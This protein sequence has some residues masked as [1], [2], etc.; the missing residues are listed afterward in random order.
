MASTDRVLPHNLEAEKSVLGAILL[1]NEALIEASEHLEPAHFFREAH[2]RIYT[3]MLGLSAAGVV[4]DL[5]TLK[6]VLTKEGELEEIGGP[7][8]IAAFIDGVPKSTSVAH[9]ARIVREKSDLRQAIF[10][11]NK[12]LTDAYDAD[13]QAAAVVE[14]AEQAIRALSDRATTTGFESMAAIAPRAMD[15]LERMHQT[16]GG[17]SGVPTGFT[18]LDHTIRG[19]QPGTLVVVG[20][21]P[22][23]GKTSLGLNV[24]SHAA[25][26]GRRVGF[27]SLEMPN[28]ELFIRLIAALAQVD[29]HRLQAGYIGEGEWR[30]VAEAMGIL[31]DRSI[32]SDETPAIGLAQVR[33]RARRVAQDRGL[34]LLVID[35]LQLMSTP[36]TYDT[37]AMEVGAVTSG[38]K[39][40]AKELKI[41]ILLLSQLSRDH[42]KRGERPRLADL[43]DSGCVEQDSD[44]VLFLYRKDDQEP[45]PNGSHLTELIIAKHRNGRTGTIKLSWFEQFTR[46]ENYS[47]APAE[48]EDRRLP[49]GDRS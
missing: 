15:L 25:A 22:G 45:L 24:A 3:H 35:Y 36:G 28:E 11:A 26:A 32:L 20:A 18:E 19:L 2:R 42:D 33:A 44:I 41:P 47:E 13:Q 49:M 37:R 23:V 16:R 7:A 8:Y 21:R 30:R 5:V 38:L 1:H 14:H 10:T 40:L 39:A 27:F 4:I 46:F 48:P 34:D 43:R 6:D 12:M 9:Y 17:V 29:S 31:A